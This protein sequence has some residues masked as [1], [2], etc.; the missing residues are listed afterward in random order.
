MF[1]L[2][3]VWT[4]RNDRMWNQKSM[5]AADVSIQLVSGL[6][7]FRF[8]NSGVPKPV[9]SKTG[10]KWRPHSFGYCKINVDGAFYHSTR[11][12]GWSF[13]VRDL[14][15]MMLAG[16][17]GPI[18]SLI[19]AEHAELLACCKAIEFAQVHG[20]CPAILETDAM[21]VKRQ[22]QEL[23]IPNTT[24]LGRV[25]EDLQVSMQ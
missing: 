4:E 25:Y 10:T 17:A 9:Q 16:G 22:L 24:V 18:R 14:C 2:W 8:H 1:I 21:E 11:S 20:F 23:S 3:S 7:E 12:G 13:V 19:S 5:L 6:T 15:G